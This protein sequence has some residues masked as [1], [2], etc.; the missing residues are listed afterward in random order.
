MNDIEKTLQNLEDSFTQFQEKYEKRWKH[1]SQ[2]FKTSSN[3][4]AFVD[5]MRTG[6]MT[7]KSLTAGDTPGSYLVPSPV[8]RMID[9]QMEN[10]NPLRKLA[11]TFSIQ[12][13]R[14]E[15][16]FEKQ[17]TNVGWVHET[18]D[19]LETNINGLRQQII[20]THTLYAKPRVTQ[21]I[22]D[23]SG[24]DVTEWISKNISE[25]MSL[26]EKQAFLKGDG[27]KQPKGFLTHPFVSCG[28]GTHETLEKIEGEFSPDLFFQTLAS[29]E[30]KY[31]HQSVWIMGRKSLAKIQAFKGSMLWQASMA[32]K[33]PS[34]LLGHPVHIM[35]EMEDMICFGNFYEAYYIVDRQGVTLLR[36]PYSAK[37]YVEIYATKRVGGSLVNGNALKI[38]KI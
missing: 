1:L 19:R 20:S 27:D 21:Q 29:L 10:L 6:R 3:D 22:L 5:F 26:A 8:V 17:E 2:D 7:Q 11:R 35:D 34:T 32:E 37:P 28:K 15:L 18:E 16:L 31:L 24:I 9:D 38:L 13:D 36:D 14:L 33:M 30:G 25:S 12:T 4:P 23:D